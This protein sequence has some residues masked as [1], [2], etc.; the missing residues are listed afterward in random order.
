M[1]WIRKKPK[2]LY[3]DMDECLF[4]NSE[5]YGPV[6]Y[7]KMLNEFCEQTGYKISFSSVWGSAMETPMNA[8]QILKCL[9]ICQRHLLSK[10][11]FFQKPETYSSR[12]ILPDIFPDR[13]KNNIH[14]TL[15]S[16]GFRGSNVAV[17]EDLLGGFEE[18]IY[19]DD[20]S[21]FFPDQLE[22]LVQV[23]AIA[24]FTPRNYWQLMAMAGQEDYGMGQGTFIPARNVP[25]TEEGVVPYSHEVAYGIGTKVQAGHFKFETTT[26]IEPGEKLRT[27]VNVKPYR[28]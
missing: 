10:Y 14:R 22:R 28:G 4:L 11:D 23:D 25:V 7:A 12:D 26:D 2:V 6:P 18:V 8:Q 21:D 16:G 3:V 24:G 9:G 1:E 20:S 17:H 19:L 13:I 15:T 5:P 27:G